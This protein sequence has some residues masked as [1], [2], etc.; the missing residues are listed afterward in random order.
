MPDVP[1][2]NPDLADLAGLLGEEN[3]RTLVRTF[4]REYPLLLAEMK[5]G[6]RKTRHRVVHSLK[7]NSRVIGAR[8]LSTRKGFSKS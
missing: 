6:D 3:V 2:P 7:S 4:L 8:D 5:A 1:P